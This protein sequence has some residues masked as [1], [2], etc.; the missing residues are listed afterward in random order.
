MPVPERMPTRSAGCGSG[1]T[2]DLSHKFNYLGNMQGL[3]KW[4]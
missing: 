4:I 3:P 2:P 1:E